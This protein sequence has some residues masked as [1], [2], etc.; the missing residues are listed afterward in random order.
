[1]RKLLLA[2]TALIALSA[3]PAKADPVFT[4]NF[5]IDHCTGTCGPAGTIFGSLTLTDTAAGVDFDVSV[6]NGAVFNF[7]GNGHTTFSFSATPT[8]TAA[9]FSITTA[10][11]A[12]VI[13]N[14][15]QD[16]FGDFKYGVNHT[17]NG[18]S[19]SDLIFSV[20]GLNFSDFIKSTNGNPNVFFAIDVLGPNGKTGLIGDS[21]L[22]IN[23]VIAPVPE[24]STWAM[25]LL[26]F[27]GVGFVAY[28]R[29]RQGGAF[30]LA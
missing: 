28:R 8:L 2:T 21:D 15:N 17:A 16:G 27:A 6:L 9:A 29:K 30:R 4:T 14:A 18:T 13:P 25:M 24:A 11:Y 1:M 7:N 23:P 20:A 22:S 3:V 26:G 5:T 12:A 10:G 19:S